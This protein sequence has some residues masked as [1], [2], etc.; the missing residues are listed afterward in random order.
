MHRETII[1]REIKLLK[2]KFEILEKNRQFRG[3]LQKST[4]VSAD[5]AGA[6][7][8][9][10]ISG[11]EGSADGANRK[12]S[13]TGTMLTMSELDSFGAAGLA[14][15]R[16]QTMITSSS[17]AKGARKSVRIKMSN[18]GGGLGQI[19]GP[20]LRLTSRPKR[21]AMASRSKRRKSNKVSSIT[22]ASD[23]VNSELGAAA[24]A[25][26]NHLDSTTTAATDVSLVNG[27]T[28]TAAAIV[29]DG[30][31]EPGAANSQLANHH[32]QQ[33]QQQQQQ[34]DSS[35]AKIKSKKSSILGRIFSAS[36]R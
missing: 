18:L 32:P 6:P 11:L 1:S 16:R 23:N 20:L 3:M 7:S 15:D 22:S 34:S 4:S 35:A 31:G 17:S 36:T 21:R 9:D 13:E 5:G 14:D 12:R 24:L 30:G 28:L 2:N 19:F 26:A 8:E 27:A 33:Q 25:T 29:A 10:L